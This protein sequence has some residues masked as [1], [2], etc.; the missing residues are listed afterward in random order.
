LH[1]KGKQFPV[2]EQSFLKAGTVADDNILRVEYRARKMM[3]I[4]SAENFDQVLLT[5]E[6]PQQ[7]MNQPNVFHG[8]PNG[9]LMQE[10]ERT[11]LIKEQSSRQDI[12][13]PL[14][15]TSL[16]KNSVKKS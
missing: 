5:L 11:D 14:S 13:Y 3:A 2:P 1:G 9:G 6:V 10:T 16:G 15:A 7:L 12:K 8:N 4:G